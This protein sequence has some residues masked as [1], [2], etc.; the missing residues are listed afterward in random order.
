MFKRF[1]ALAAAAA[2]ALICPAAFAAEPLPQDMLCHVGA[3]RL[4]DGALVDVAPSD[5]S[6]RWRLLD[7]RTGALSRK[8]GVWVSTRGWTGQ[9]DGVSVS[10]GP[11]GAGAIVFEG[12]SGQRAP[13]VVRETTF[14]GAD[15]VELAGRLVM[16]SGQSQVPLAVLVHGSEDFSAR[17]RYFEQRVWPLN[18]VGVFVYDKRGT[19]GSKGRYTQDFH[20]L[21]RDA[22]AAVA[23]ARRLG[24]ER[25]SRIGLDGGSQGG[26]IAPLAATLV[27]VDYVIARYGLAEGPLAEDR[28]EVLLGLAEK[29]YAPDVLAKAREVTAATGKIVLTG[30]KDGWEEL[31]E[32]KRRYGAEPW[33]RDIEGE[34]SGEILRNPPEAVRVIGPQRDKGT[35]WSYEPMPVLRAV[36]APML[37]ILAAEDRE[38]P[39]AETRRRLAGLAT[40]GRP[41]TILE[42]PGTDHGI[43]EFEMVDGERRAVRY[44]EGYFRAVLD[45]ARYG[46]VDGGY[47]AAVRLSP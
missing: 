7:G 22:A 43:V 17:E 8:D 14:T 18:G 34:F 27:P 47:G 37:W 13:L 30:F 41:I 31:A 24:G 21:A 29:G 45:F 42:F 10:F 33:F 39:V 11:C 20:I 36:E 26:W 6:L 38:A 9:S 15:G 28:E 25:I 32:V 3:Y 5:G 44:A 16:P 1:F 40:E 12:K 19:G 4:S 23:E 35:S 2:A 46:K